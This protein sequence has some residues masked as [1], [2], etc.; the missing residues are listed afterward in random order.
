MHK[1]ISDSTVFF[2]SIDAGKFTPFSLSLHAN[3]SRVD[4]VDQA[5]KA[6]SVH[7]DHV[8]GVIKLCTGKGY[9]D[10]TYGLA[11]LCNCYRGKQTNATPQFVYNWPCIECPHAGLT[12]S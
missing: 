2:A 4:K 9:H 11:E 1:T 8:G 5:V 6:A 7:V 3:W 12:G 10:Q